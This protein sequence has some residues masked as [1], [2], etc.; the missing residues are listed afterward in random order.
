MKSRVSDLVVSWLTART[1]VTAAV[2]VIFA[3]LIELLLF[4]DYHRRIFAELFQDAADLRFDK[5]FVRVIPYLTFAILLFAF[6]YL[7][8]KSTRVVGF[9]YLLWFSVGCFYEYAYQYLFHRFSTIHD[10]GL[11][12]LTTSTQQVDAISS[13]KSFYALVPCLAYLTILVGPRKTRP[14]SFWK[15]VVGLGLITAIV[16]TLTL[17]MWFAAPRYYFYD[18]WSNSFVASTRTLFGY[19]VSRTLVADSVREPVTPMTSR[20]TNNIVLVIDESV[21]GDHLGLNGYY[22]DTTPFLNELA[23]REV[24]FNW[25]ITAAAST[26]SEE[27]FQYIAT[28]ISP[29]SSG[30]IWA[31]LKTYPTMFQYAKAAN[32]KTYY[33]DG[34]QNEYWGGNAGDTQYIDAVVGSKYFEGDGADQW[35]IDQRIAAKAKEIITG[36]SGNFVV[37]FKRG[38]HTPYSYTFPTG[39]EQWQPSLMSQEL[40]VA[41]TKTLINT[42]DNGLRYNLDVFFRTLVDDYDNIPNRTV[43]FYTGDHG[44]TLSEGGEVYSHGGDSVREATVPL[45]LIGHVETAPDT[46]FKPMH[47]NILPS[48]LDL[49]NY[50]DEWRKQAYVV[51][52]F[53]AKASDS[54]QRF[55]LTPHVMPGDTFIETLALRKFDQD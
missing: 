1:T 40:D 11:V 2:F 9:L 41:N 7:S 8:L 35:D 36:S 12:F 18:A 51:S 47:A 34:Q 39:G 4:A 10:L 55:Y 29:E 20:P 54:R 6:V 27:S 23:R 43:I 22:R 13:Y 31:S 53:R 16:M 30:E 28:G 5:V 37:I 25:G 50:P 21:R 3:L 44:Q 24:L 19:V 42:Y 26:R 17:A 38:S 32:Y 14:L 15:S 49:M 46:G 45:F 52:L 48:I 33:L